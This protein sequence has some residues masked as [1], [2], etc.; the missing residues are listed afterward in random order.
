MK[1]L[2]E[3]ALKKEEAKVDVPRSN[4]LVSEKAR[5]LQEEALKKKESAKQANAGEPENAAVTEKMK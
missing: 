1:C 3:Q 5:W 4:A 2:Q